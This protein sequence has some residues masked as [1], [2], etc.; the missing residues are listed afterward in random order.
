MQRLHF[1]LDS[2]DTEGSAPSKEEANQSNF[3]H[4]LVLQC[5]VALLL[6]GALVS[7]WTAISQTSYG[8]A[9]SS[10]V[11]GVAFIHYVLIL[12]ER[13]KQQ[14]EDSNNRVSGYRLADWLA[15]MPLLALKTLHLARDGPKPLSPFLNSAYIPTAVAATAF[16][17][18]MCGVLAVA[19]T[20]RFS[21]STGGS[22]LATTYRWTLYSIG[23]LLLGVLYTILFITAIDSESVHMTEV[24]GFSL[25]WSVY[26]LITALEAVLGDTPIVD[27]LYAAADVSSKVFLSI[28]SVV[29]AYGVQHAAPRP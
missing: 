2:V 11:C 15:T 21:V 29:I 18:I 5:T 7:A 19:G 23:V 3:L 25:L 6:G 28:Y 4:F 8:A 17:M 12:S 13:M 1:S 20:Q 22:C 9:L 24:F 14:T 16:T 26:P 10:A 27:A